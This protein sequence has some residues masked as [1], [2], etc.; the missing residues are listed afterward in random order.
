MEGTPIDINE[1]FGEDG[2]NPEAPKVETPKEET[3]KEETTPDPAPVEEEEEEEEETTNET[4]SLPDFLLKAGILSEDPGEVDE[5]TL[6]D[7]V[8]QETETYVQEALTATFDSWKSKLPSNV[9]GLVQHTFNGGDADEYMKTWNETPLQLFDINSESGQESFLRFY[10]KSAEGLEGEELDDKMDYHIDR[11][12]VETAAK[13]FYQKMANE[14]D[15]KLEALA[16]QQIEAKQQAERQSM[17]RKQK[18]AQGM[19]KV[20]DFAGYSFPEGE[21]K[22]LVRYATQPVLVE[23]KPFSSGLAAD[24]YEALSD[25]SKVLLLSKLV[26]SGFDTSFIEKKGQTKAVKAVKKTLE[27][28]ASPPILEDGVIWD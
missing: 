7:L 20:K 19:T 27:Q 23:G 18:L 1:L 21:K 2:F 6:L 14:R 4:F 11:G 28:P 9:M 16:K 12:N 26:K 24:L 5:E 22:V 3:P 10:Y 17:E 25:P 15:K 13:R 8:Q